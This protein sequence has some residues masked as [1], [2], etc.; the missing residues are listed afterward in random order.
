MKAATPSLSLQDADAFEHFARLARPRVYSTALRLVG[1]PTEAEDITQEAFLRA[2]GHFAGFDRSKSF[3]GWICRIVT[4]LSTDA[5]RRRRV[6]R[7]CSLDTVGVNEARVPLEFASSSP[8]VYVL[9]HEMDERLARALRSLPSHYRDP[10][11]AAVIGQ[12]AHSAIAARLHCPVT[13]IRS[14]IH[15]AR[16]M[17][18]SLLKEFASEQCAGAD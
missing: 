6:V 17:M 8:E 16:Q 4:N 1:D 18:R 13:T 5:F 3:E 10:L 9:Q 15:R 11:I 2:W 14:R 7:F 12:E